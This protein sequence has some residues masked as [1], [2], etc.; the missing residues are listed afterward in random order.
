MIRLI[1]LVIIP[2]LAASEAAITL[3]TAAITPKAV[4]ISETHQ[5]HLLPIHI[6]YI[7]AMEIREEIAVTAISVSTAMLLA[8]LAYAAP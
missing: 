7:I 5:A 1:R 6:P 2:V 8:E 3:Y 4:S